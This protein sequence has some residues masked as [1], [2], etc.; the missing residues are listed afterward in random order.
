LKALLWARALERN[1]GALEPT[2]QFTAYCAIFPQNL[3][4][5][6]NDL[7]NAKIPKLVKKSE[8]NKAKG[9]TSAN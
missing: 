1:R 9:V 4:F 3:N 5:S 6:L 8:N 2:W 7:Q